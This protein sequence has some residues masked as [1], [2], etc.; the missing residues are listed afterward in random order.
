MVT[1]LD[2][3][4]HLADVVTVFLN[5]H[6][7]DNEHIWIWLPDSRTVKVKKALYGLRRSP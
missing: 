5:G 2:L 7:D 1:A 3:K 4:C 6:L